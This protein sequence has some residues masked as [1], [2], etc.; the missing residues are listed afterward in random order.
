MQLYRIFARPRGDA[1]SVKATAFALVAVAL[2]VVAFG[3]LRVERQHEV[4]ELGYRLA[5]T[6]SQLDALREQ[7]RGLE[8]E[9]ATLTA[10]DR[11]RRLASE[12]GMT[13]VEPDKIRVIHPALRAAN[14]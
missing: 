6:S 13:T 12:L 7:R 1:A 5:K 14:P 11:I 8:A 2:V 4:L 9:R 3:V 10:P